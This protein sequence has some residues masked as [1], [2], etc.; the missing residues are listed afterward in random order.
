MKQ[1][2]RTRGTTFAAVVAEP[3]ET[4]LGWQAYFGIA[5]VLSPLRDLDKWVLCPLRCH[6][7]QK[8][9]RAGY[10][11]LR[12]TWRVCAR[13][14]AYQQVRTRSM[15]GVADAGPVDRAP[16]ALLRKNGTAEP[17]AAAG[18]CFIEPPDT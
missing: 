8:W 7:W 4:L 12:K 2:R 14:V 17:R 9:G 3:G 16:V 13:S 11:E 1:T 15:A 6:L 10:R 18:I 5:E